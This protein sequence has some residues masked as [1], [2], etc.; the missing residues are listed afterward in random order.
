MAR[1]YIRTIFTDQ[2]RTLQERDGSRDG[3]ARME[4][5][6]PTTID[7]LSDREAE[8]VSARDSFYMASITADGWPYVQHRGGPPGFLQ[9]L[10]GN[11]LG[12]ADYRGNR[13]FVSMANLTE[14]PRVALFL[15][16][17]PN[18]RRLKMVGMASVVT[19][20]EDAALVARL[21]PDGY[22]A[23]AERAFLIDIIGFDWNCPQHITPRFTE[24]EIAAAVAPLNAELANLRAEVARLQTITSQKEESA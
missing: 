4:G 12:F 2:A 23:I 16:D 14:N 5:D 20:E 18:R 15:V 24:S 10:P 3:Y 7:E 1:N 19:A 9:V 21:M 11:R 13:Q 22:K 6:A 17:Y 8:F